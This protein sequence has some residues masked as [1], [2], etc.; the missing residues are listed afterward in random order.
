MA[1]VRMV[2]RL[3]W[4]DGLLTPTIFLPEE[5]SARLTFGL[6]IRLD[7]RWDSLTATDTRP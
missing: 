2:I 5:M 6:K 7:S 3:T 1:R 4:Q